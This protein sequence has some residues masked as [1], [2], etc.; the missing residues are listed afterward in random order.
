M[1]NGVVTLSGTVNSR[2]EKRMAEDI[3]QSVSGVS[4]VQNNLRINRQ[5]GQT[6]WSR[7]N[8]GIT[9]ESEMNQGIQGTQTQEE[10][11]TTETSKKRR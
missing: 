5:T 10:T 7:G 4:D 8:R 1:N 9:G 3:A 2:E 11:D 6:D